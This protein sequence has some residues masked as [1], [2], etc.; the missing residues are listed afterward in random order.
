MPV[1]S[2]SPSTLALI[3]TV[4]AV[5]LPIVVLPLTVR[6]PSVRTLPVADATVNLSVVPDLT[7]K[8]PSAFNCPL[9]SAIPVTVRLP[10]SVD[11]PVP[12]T[13]NVPVDCMSI[14]RPFLNCRSPAPSVHTEPDALPPVTFKLPVSVRPNF[15]HAAPV[16]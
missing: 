13:C 7:A 8:L 9:N 15:A 5:S 14:P 16:Q 11:A 4:S 6:L 2:R 3:V 10:P 1:G 12:D